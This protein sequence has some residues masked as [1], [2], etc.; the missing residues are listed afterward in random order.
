MLEIV[1]VASG[2]DALLA[3]VRIL[4]KRMLNDCV[5]HTDREEGWILEFQSLTEC[6]IYFQ[7][8]RPQF[9]HLH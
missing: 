3:N 9:H 4:G 1:Y 5:S 6:K 8:L 2:F 7:R